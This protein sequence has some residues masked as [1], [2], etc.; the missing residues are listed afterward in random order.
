M[1]RPQMSISQPYF[2]IDELEALLRQAPPTAET[3]RAI[4]AKSR[5]RQAL[6]PEETAQLIL[7]QNAD[8]DEEIFCCGPRT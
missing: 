6:S 7:N 4:I 1:N 2:S 5:R 8:L 3:I